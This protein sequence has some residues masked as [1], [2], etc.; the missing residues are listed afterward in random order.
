MYLCR[1]TNLSDNPLV[2][3]GPNLPFQTL[4]HQ[5]LRASGQDHPKDMVLDSFEIFLVL[6]ELWA[7]HGETTTP[8]HNGVC[9][10]EAAN[11][12]RWSQ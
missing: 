8:S 4:W 10:V 6:G 3:N 12:A 9:K 11:A 1:M 5:E 7:D 2:M